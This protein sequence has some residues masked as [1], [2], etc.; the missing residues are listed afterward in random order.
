[1]PA[2]IGIFRDAFVDGQHEMEVPG[3]NPST[4][5]RLTVTTQ[6]GYGMSVKLVDFM[7]Y[8]IWQEFLEGATLQELD[9]WPTEKSG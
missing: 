2:K 8:L 6:A 5:M 4:P 3:L 9:A 1:M 7:G